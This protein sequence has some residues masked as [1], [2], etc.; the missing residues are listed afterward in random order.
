VGGA[1]G[2][3]LEGRTP[4]ARKHKRGIWKKATS[5]LTHFDR[6]QIF[7][8][9]GTPDPTQDNGPVFMPKLF[10][11]RSTFGVAK[12]ATMVS[13]SFKTYLQGEPDDCFEAGDFSPGF[14]RRDGTSS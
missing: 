10:R 6:G 1:R 7:R 14:E 5:S 9:H 13:G 12:A 2:T 4:G 8:S 3:Q 11:R